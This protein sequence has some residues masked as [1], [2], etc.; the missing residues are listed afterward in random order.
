MSRTDFQ[1]NLAVLQPRKGSHEVKAWDR[2]LQL[3]LP[4][5]GIE[6]FRYV[7]LRDLYRQ[8]YSH[9]S[10]HSEVKD[11]NIKSLVYP[12]CSLSFLVFVNGHFCEHLS[13]VPQG[14]IAI[15]LSRAFEE[16]NHFLNS[17]V[18]KLIQEESDPFALLNAALHGEGLFVYL[19]PR[20]E[21]QSCLQIIHIVE[22]NRGPV[23]LSPRIHLVL[24]KE[25]SLQVCMTQNIQEGD[26]WVNGS[27]DLVLEE[28]ASL[29]LTTLNEEREKQWHLEAIRATLKKQSRLKSYAITNG[30]AGSRQDY[31][32]HL[33][34]EGSEAILSGA[35]GLKGAREHHVNVLIEHHD[36]LCRSFQTFKG[37]L[38]DCARS[39]FEGKIYVQ[40]KAQK[41]EAYQLNNHLLLSPHTI[42]RSKP[43]LEIFAD[44]VKASHGATVGQID[45]EQLFYLKTRGIPAHLAHHLLVNGFCRD[46]I[47]SLPFASFQKKALS[48]LDL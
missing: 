20:Y 34:G 23:L 21:P 6:T 44:D 39:S 22:G 14:M 46:I 12:E 36:P 29:S 25:S 5:K 33:M 28:R 37:I 8:S 48:L 42:A 30:G 38:S 9:P 16:Y 19:P 13:R 35:W 27:I 7:K 43:N 10:T 32:V 41:T 24:G 4:D 47:D 26:I 3:G 15:P 2:F 11:H 40:S 45:E 1:E 17:R 18:T 31:S